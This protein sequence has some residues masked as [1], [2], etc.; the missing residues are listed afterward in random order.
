MKSIAVAAAILIFVNILHAEDIV[1]PAPVAVEATQPDPN[2][3]LTVR[4]LEKKDKNGNRVIT[5]LVKNSGFAEV[6]DLNADIVLHGAKEG[7]Y[8]SF[9]QKITVPRN[10]EKAFEIP[11][12]TEWLKRVIPG[13][14]AARG[15]GFLA[16]IEPVTGFKSV[17]VIIGANRF[18]S[19]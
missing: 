16:E 10:Q 2:L 15:S 8:Q 13:T 9:K 12:P 7:Q 3:K 1:V 19:L 11:A 6:K 17:E 5:V 14:P 4:W 18:S